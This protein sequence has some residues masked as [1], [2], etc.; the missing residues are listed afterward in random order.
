MFGLGGELMFIKLY[1]HNQRAYDATLKMLSERK[2]AAV[3]HPTGTGKSF[4]A[5]KLCE[6]N[7]DKCI[8]WLS[9]SEY[10][11][12]TQLENLKVATD[13]YVPKNIKFFTY[14]KLINISNEEMANLNPDFIILDEFH[15]CGAEIWGKGVQSLISEYPSVPIVGLSATSIRYLDNRRDMSDELFDGNVS[16]EITLGDA[17]VRGILNPPKY[18]LSAFSCQKDLR[19]YEKRILKNKSKIIRDEGK[20][21]LDEL[22]RTLEHAEGIDKIFLKHMTDKRGKYIVFCANYDHMQEMISI[23]KDWFSK[24]DT[25]PH[26]YSAYSNNPDTNKAFSDFKADNSNHLKLLYCIDMLNEGVHVDDISGVILLRPTVSPIIYKQQIGRALSANKTN[27]SVIFDIVLNIENLYSIGEINEEMQLV[28]AYYRSLGEDSLI[29]NEHFN[30]IDEVHDCIELFNKLEKVLTASW[31]LMYK[32]A[33]KYYEENGNL[34]V[35]ARYFSEDGYSLGCWIYNQRSIRKGQMPGTL[36]DNQIN[37]LDKIG[38]RWELRT[39]FN[40]NKNYGAALDY[41]KTFGNLDV[42]SRYITKSGIHLGEWLSNLRTWESSGVHSKYLTPERKKELEEI[43]M[44]WSKLDYYWEKNFSV[45]VK[46]YK[47]NGDLIVPSNFVSDDGVRLG[48]WISRLRKLRKGQCKGTPPTPEQIKRLDD[49]G[50][51]W[52]LNITRKWNNAYSYAK[53]YFETNGNL[54]VPSAYKTESGFSLGQWIK[55]QRK[56]FN[57]GKIDDTCKKLLN[58]IGMVWNLPDSWMFRYN[59]LK[60]YYEDN[61]NITINQS[62]VIDGVWIGKWIAVQ[63]KLYESGKTLTHEQRLLLEHLPL[64]HVAPKNNAWYIAYADAEEYYQKNNNLKV[65][66]NYKGSSGLIL[67]DWIVRQ[68]R[69]CKE[70]KLT[71]KQIMLLDKIGFIWNPES[72][73]DEGY[74]HATE[75]FETFGN[76]NMKK[77]YKC[78]DGYALGIWV[79]NYRNAHNQKN[80]PVSITKEQ[81]QKLER[82]GMVWVP[83]TIWDKRFADIQKYF[84]VN[85]KLPSS[86]SS[87]D[88]EKKL[89]QWLNNQRKSYHIGRLNEYQLKKLSEIGITSAW[90]SPADPF[91][92]GYLIAKEYYEANGNLNVPTNYCH[93]NGFWLGSWL[94]KIRQKRSELTAEQKKRLD[95]ISFVW[96]LSDNFEKRFVIA[97][98]YYNDY[99]F[100][101]LEPKQCKNSEELHICQWLRRQLLK[102]NAGKLEQD[103]I[104]RLTS[105]G[106]DWQ[107]SRERT[108]NR[109]YNKAKEY[110]A[111]NGNLNVVTS[112]V[113]EDG[114]PLGEWLH[115]QK[116]HCKRLS[117]ERINLLLNLGMVGIG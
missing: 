72:V 111:L 54:L 62:V 102:R 37:K 109:G 10:I 1:Q 57:T 85:G 59:I 56:A 86:S 94:D 91:E 97:E 19:K 50:M 53:R 13:G 14:A 22:R 35:P 98:K 113:C 92:K 82:I 7:A 100:L 99:G 45:A 30:V 93:R 5:F 81:E 32:C 95:E 47:E 49:I 70:N 78:A 101:P 84:M 83:E 28:T 33:K 40:W 51:V 75:Y 65:P 41:F 60:K 20:K 24:I 36:S 96:D 17:I 15:R 110:Y 25:A 80:S 112:Y 4:I 46:Y 2:K 74:R 52:E 26:I 103:K 116:T 73:W 69:A 12:K 39:D 117:E 106:M 16:S 104:E 23:S 76:L 63:K 67:S 9:P 44:I 58:Q 71:D 90:L 77:S 34:E 38:M 87:D 18:V 66:S 21:Y 11:F 3:I 8:C 88:L 42:S 114:Y 108:W 79:Y 105:I 43:G 55:N 48:S 68:R 6:D 29:I 27:N 64:E 61:G 31:D 115:S 107:N 89:Y